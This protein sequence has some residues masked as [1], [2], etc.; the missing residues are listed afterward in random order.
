MNMTTTQ[1]ERDVCLQFLEVC[2]TR[3]MLANTTDQ[4]MDAIVNAHFDGI[5]HESPHLVHKVA[6]VKVQ[7]LKAMQIGWA[8]YEMELLAAL[9][10][11]YAQYFS[12]EEMEEMIELYQNPTLQKMVG[13]TPQLQAEGSSVGRLIGEKA[14]EMAGKI[15]QEMLGGESD[16]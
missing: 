13:L 5:L 4:V 3:Q 16:A 10:E 12:V 7:A 6:E 14:G 8:Q 9:G 2:G 1:A 11:I 15:L